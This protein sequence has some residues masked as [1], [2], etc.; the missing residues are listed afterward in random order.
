MF[1]AALTKRTATN[2][3][4]YSLAVQRKRL[5]P[6][7]EKELGSLRV[8]SF[9]RPQNSRVV[10]GIPSDY[11]WNRAAELGQTEAYFRAGGALPLREGRESLI[12]L[13]FSALF[14][15][16]F[17]VEREMCGGEV[18]DANASRARIGARRTS[19]ACCLTSAVLPFRTANLCLTAIA[20]IAL[21]F[22]GENLLAIKSHSPFIWKF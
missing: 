8:W 13:L 5:A 16:I 21:R 11:N 1:A 12:I 7:S 10:L 15:H 20:K 9:Y 6:E 3:H 18:W 17:H 22:I 2:L 4:E 19:A 14:I